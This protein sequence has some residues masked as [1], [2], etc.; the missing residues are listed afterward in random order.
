MNE[1]ART[2][3]GVAPLTQLASSIENPTHVLR[4]ILEDVVAHSPR[5]AAEFIGRLGWPDTPVPILFLFF[6]LAVLVL[7]DL[8]DH[9]P[10]V[11][12][13][14]TTRLILASLVS[15]TVVAIIFSQYVIW[16]PVGADLIE[17]TQGRHFYPIA[18]F[19]VWLFWSRQRMFGIPKSLLR[20]TAVGAV[21]LSLAVT[22]DAVIGR[23]YGG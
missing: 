4:V 17:G 9:E 8:A 14:N 6:F 5:Y 22:F 7:L 10:L 21:V 23:Y 15:L 3:V 18:P 12:I 20:A 19:A 1:P 11:I 2:G 13:E 16:T